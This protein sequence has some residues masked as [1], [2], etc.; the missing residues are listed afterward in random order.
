[1]I[2]LVFPRSSSV[3]AVMSSSD[4]DYLGG[5]MVVGTRST[6][7]DQGGSLY[8]F[9]GSGGTIYLAVGLSIINEGGCEDF[10]RFHMRV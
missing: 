3:S 6:V 2:G 5:S 1:M 9:N 4:G 8:L 10:L 7:D